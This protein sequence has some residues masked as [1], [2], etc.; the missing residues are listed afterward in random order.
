MS[1]ALKLSLAAGTLA[2][3]LVV[4]AVAVG[5]STLGG[6][7]AGGAAEPRGAASRARSAAVHRGAD[8]Q[9][10][11]RSWTAWPSRAWS[12]P[13]S[14]GRRPAAGDGPERSRGQSRLLRLPR[15]AAASRRRRRAAVLL[16]G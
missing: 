2:L 10:L 4:A 7:D 15:Q 14:P 11:R 9:A 3:L 8:P 6:D 1:R 16:I 5:V 12:R 13:R